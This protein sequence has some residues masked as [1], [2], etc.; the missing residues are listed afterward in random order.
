[1]KRTTSQWRSVSSGM[2]LARAIDSAIDSFH[3]SGWS[4]NPSWSTSIGASA[5]SVVVIAVPP[6]SGIDGF[7]L[8]ARGRHRRSDSRD[9]AAREQ[10]VPVGP[11][12]HELPEVVQPRLAQEREAER[13]REVAGQRL[14]LV[15][16]VDQQ[17]L[18]EARL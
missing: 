8:L 10:R 7:A 1:M 11:L 2:S 12:E 9:L 14:G 17:C 18:V 13:G 5:I 15:V 6:S 16:E 3:C 4:R